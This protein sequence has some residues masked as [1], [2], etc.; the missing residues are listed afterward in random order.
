MQMAIRKPDLRA[1]WGGQVYFL[2]MEYL[3]QAFII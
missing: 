3:G 1:G 2:D